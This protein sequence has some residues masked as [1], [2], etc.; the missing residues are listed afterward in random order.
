MPGNAYAFLGTIVSLSTEGWIYGNQL[1]C[2]H[3]GPAGDVVSTANTEKTETAQATEEGA[4]ASGMSVMVKIAL[5]VIIP[6]I[7]G[8]LINLG[9]VAMGF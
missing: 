3:D 2:R 5:V 9:L 6:F 7:G 8:Y 4:N 1:V